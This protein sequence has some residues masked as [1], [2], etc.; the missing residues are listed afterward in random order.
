MNLT[1]FYILIIKKKYI[2]NGFAGL[3]IIAAF[4]NNNK[5]YFLFSSVSNVGFLFLN[6]SFDFFKKSLKFDKHD[7]FIKYVIKLLK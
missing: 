1:M 5:I 2:G 3:D 6:I 4:K 7:A